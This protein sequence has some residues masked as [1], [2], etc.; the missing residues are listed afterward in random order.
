MFACINN[1]T[2]N[3][4]VLRSA[5]ES[6]AIQSFQTLLPVAGQCCSTVLSQ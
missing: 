2:Q 1:T 3:L 4:F 6:L 5:F